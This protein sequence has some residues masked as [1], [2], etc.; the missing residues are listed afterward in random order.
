MP[1]GAVYRRILRKLGC[2]PQ[3]QTVE[4]DGDNLGPTM[5]LRSWGPTM[6]VEKLS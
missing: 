5:M 2:L 1:T 4:V 3:W 6:M